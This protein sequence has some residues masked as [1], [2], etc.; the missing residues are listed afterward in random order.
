MKA[1]LEI[2]ALLPDRRIRSHFPQYCI[3]LEEEAG[4]CIHEMIFNSSLECLSH[5]G[6]LGSKWLQPHLQL[7]L[8]QVHFPQ[9]TCPVHAR[10]QSK[11]VAPLL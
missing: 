9:D 8:H 7:Q 3:K 5:E 4:K 2:L 6:Q 10:Q 11:D 1:G